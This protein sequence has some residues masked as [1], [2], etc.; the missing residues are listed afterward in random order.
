MP[1]AHLGK[2]LPDAAAI[3]LFAEHHIVH[4][5]RRKNGEIVAVKHST[6]GWMSPAGYYGL[7]K[8]HDAIPVLGPVLAGAYQMK[9]AIASSSIGVAGVSV[10]IG[11]ALYGGSLA[12]A[13]IL[14]TND[15]YHT[16][17]SLAPVLDIIEFFENKH[18]SE[19]Q[20]AGINKAAH[21]EGTLLLAGVLLPFGE[22]LLL[23]ALTQMLQQKPYRWEDFYNWV[24]SIG[25]E[26]LGITIQERGL[27]PGFE[28]II[29]GKRGHHGPGRF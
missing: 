23:F 19:E 25:Q 13:S 21:S 10:P 11:T 14:L 3:Q 22:I 16:A 1:R 17:S 9:W 24:Q 29:T 26:L 12:L 28:D 15:P 18:P 7:Q 2:R 6:F 5:R 4:V 8:L 27:H 20:I